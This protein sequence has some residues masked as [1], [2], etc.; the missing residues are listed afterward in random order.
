MNAFYGCLVAVVAGTVVTA[1][2]SHAAT[3]IEW[4]AY[5]AD[6]G[7]S[8]YSPAAQITPTNVGQLR[9]A[10]TY[11]TGDLL[12]NNLT[13][14]GRGRFEATPLFVDGKLYLS[15]PRGLVIALDPE[16][17][18]ERWRYDANVD[19]GGNYGDF[20]NRGVSTW[21]DSAAGA[22]TPCQ[23]RVFLAAIDARL[24]ALDAATGGLCENFGKAGIV[25]LTAGLPILPSYKGEYAVTSPPAIYRDSV[26][27]GSAVADNRRFD[28]PSGVVRAYDAR[29]GVLRWTWDPIPRDPTAV[30]YDTWQGPR[31]HE[32]GAANVWSIISV[33]SARGLVFLP[34]GSASPDFFGGSRLGSNLYAN[35]VVAL[36]AATGQVAWHFQVVHHDL[37]DYDVPAEPVLVT[38]HRDGRKIDSVVVAT[39]MGHLFVLDRDTGQPLLPVEE[40]S[41]P[42]SDVAGEQASPTQPF[43][44]LPPPLTPERLSPSDVWGP[45]PEA[46][47][48]CVRRL[49]GV[50][51]DGMFTPPS[52]R[53]TILFPGNIGGS[54]WGGIAWD[55]I[56]NILVGPTNRLAFL[57]H[58][59]PRE[60]PNA[61]S[62]IVDETPG[63]DFGPQIG[64]PYVVVRERFWSSDRIPCNAPPFG[65]LFAMDM[66]LWSKRWERPLGSMPGLHRYTGYRDWGSVNLGG[67]MLTRSGV[68]FA[69]GGFD[70]LLHAF[71]VRNGAELWSAPLPAGGHATPMTYQTASGTQFVVLSAGGHDALGTR[72]GDYVV[73]FALPRAPTRIGHKPAPLT[74][75]YAGELRIGGNRFKAAWTIEHHGVAVTGAFSGD[76]ST[77]NGEFKGTSVRGGLRLEGTWT[78]V[79]KACAGTFN[80]I[81]ATA[82]GAQLLEG[83]IHVKGTCTEGEEVGA[84]V[85]RRSRQ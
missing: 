75:T 26:I 19:I 29:T 23:R 66:S 14:E 81:A 17:G 1:S 10:W 12:Y 44:V 35:S 18:A 80:A 41:V 61:S 34:V 24:I 30:F 62:V 13:G 39:K 28:A 68:A 84:M 77:I 21:L 2:V 83:P 79:A 33:D 6:E 50:R 73:A 27:V 31:A 70:E 52:L 45:T 38:I 71:D 67:V 25:D 37:W 7:G 20:A 48:Q 46:R 15:T 9:L 22:D 43:P 58:L 49:T 36:H 55:P 65:T 4:T 11:R 51:S 53:G 82:N 5:G 57:V 8:R 3:P 32:T 47:S 54:N 76:G 74:G 85:L 59:V 16:R 42:A 56:R 78:L 64:T 60:Q 72:H 69:S 40:R 63:W